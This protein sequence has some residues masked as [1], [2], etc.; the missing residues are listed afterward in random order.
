MRDLPEGAAGTI[1][2]AMSRL[3]ADRGSLPEEVANM[4]A[5]LATEAGAY[6]EATAVS[7][8]GGMTDC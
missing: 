2:Q 5:F 1:P 7:V 6:V 4:V 3:S 8:G